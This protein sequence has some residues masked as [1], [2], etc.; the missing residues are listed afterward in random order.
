MIKKIW[1]Q[2]YLVQKIRPKEIQIKKFFGTTLFWVQTNFLVQK[3]LG[4][5]KFDQ[6]RIRASKKCG[7]KSL[8]KIRSDS[9]DMDKCCHDIYD[10]WTNVT[11]TFGIVRICSRCSQEPP[12]KIVK[13]GSI[14]AEILLTLGFCGGWGGGM[15]SHFH[16]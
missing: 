6:K 7:P 14:T 4:Q 13:I 9:A 16:V 15:Q 8:L 5:K 10:S 11:M 2:K 1:V 12:F 3:Y